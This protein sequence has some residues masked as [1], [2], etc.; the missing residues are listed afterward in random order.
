M[1]QITTETILQ[2][3]NTFIRNLI[4]VYNLRISYPYIIIYLTD[5]DISAAFRHVK[6][7]LFIAGAFAYIANELLIIP[8]AQT[9]GSTTSP[10]N[11]ECLAQARAWLS[12]CF[13][14][15]AYSHLLTKHK[16]YLDMMHFDYSYEGSPQCITAACVADS[17]N[18]GIMENGIPINTPHNPYVDD[19][20][21][22]DIKGHIEQAIVASVESCF[23]IFGDRDD[24]LRPCPLSLEK[25]QSSVCSPIRQQ[26]GIVVNTNTMT[27]SLPTDKLKNLQNLLLPFHPFRAKCSIYQGAQLLGVLDHVGQY[28]PFFRH[29]YISIRESFNSALKSAGHTFDKSDEFIK[30]LTLAESYTDECKRRKALRRIAKQRAHEIYHGRHQDVSVWITKN[31]RNDINLI[32]A[33]AEDIDFWQ[34]PIPHII[35]RIHDFT[36]YCDSCKYGAGGYCP[37]LKFMWHIH[38][39]HKDTSIDELLESED[40]THI[41]LLEYTAVIITY[42][43]AQRI[44]NSNPDIASHTYPT[45]NILS[46]NTTACSWS[47][48]GASSSNS[49]A[50]HITHIAGS[51]QLN[52]RLGMHVTHIQ[53]EDNIVADAIS[54]I[55]TNLPIL[56][57]LQ[58]VKQE[59]SSLKNC[60]IAQ[61]PRNLNSLIT[62]LFSNKSEKLTIQWIRDKRH[63]I[64]VSDSFSIGSLLSD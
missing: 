38:W 15:P 46:D 30:A 36:A 52:T 2:Y 33:L 14:S 58:K 23:L 8:T 34:T 4:R 28:M 53:G 27:I 63:L 61:I 16:E 60:A 62:V 21:M 19:T 29:L 10:S 25:F 32:L 51:L 6:Y 22:A 47:S 49:I 17:L 18:H 37:E 9:F 55:A 50:K 35:P 3:G 42:A 59:H 56:S 24:N 11:Y 41:N 20:L 5:D 45:I 26:L 13:S 1:H 54:R 39:P 40:V 57:Q 43:I 7:N 31:F 48:K 12:K 44:L 64:P